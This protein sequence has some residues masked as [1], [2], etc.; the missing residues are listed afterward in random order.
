MDLDEFIQLKSREL[1][2][3]RACS[4]TLRNSYTQWYEEE[5][6]PSKEDKEQQK[7]WWKKSY[8]MNGKGEVLKESASS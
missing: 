2:E 1:E 6:Q 7:W 8:A 4:Q 5:I 3:C